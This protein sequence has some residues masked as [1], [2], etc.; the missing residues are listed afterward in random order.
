ML[1]LV[2]H[3]SSS[4]GLLELCGAVDAQL[5]RTGPSR[6]LT[7]DQARG[8]T[9]PRGGLLVLGAPSLPE[10]GGRA[11]SDWLADAAVPLDTAVALFEAGPGTST[12]GSVAFRLRQQARRRGLWSVCRPQLFLEDQATGALLPG[13]VQRAERWAVALG[14]LAGAA[15]A[16]GA[17]DAVDAVDARAGAAV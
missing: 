12:A 14:A 13:E 1:A 16:A 4:P 5:S 6:V 3:P 9:A 7:V 10:H 2:I 17:D 11:V 15:G 8:T